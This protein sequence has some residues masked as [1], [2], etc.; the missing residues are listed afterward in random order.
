MEEHFFYHSFPRG[1]NKNDQKSI[2]QAIAILESIR[3]WSI[4]GTTGY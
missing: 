2:D 4:D 1:S 3:D